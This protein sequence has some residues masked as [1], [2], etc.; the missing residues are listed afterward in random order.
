MRTWTVHDWVAHA[1][2]ELDRRIALALRAR[3]T[4]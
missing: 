1:L 2:S 3:S 4:K